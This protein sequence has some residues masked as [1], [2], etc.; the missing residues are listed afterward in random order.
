VFE[1]RRLILAICLGVLGFTIGCGSGGPQV[2]PV[3]GTVSFD[4]QPVPE[5]EIIFFPA[6]MSTPYVGKITNGAFECRLPAGEN[7]VEI[8]ATR[9][10]PTPAPDGLPNYESYIPSAYN[11]Q[12]TLTAS[13][14]PEGDNAF[15][16]EL[17]AQ[18]PRG[19]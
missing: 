16:F 15:T 2:Y 9:E 1:R 6:D 8:T 17:Q 13:V 18:S 14:T 19:R 7:R 4:G 10:S 3:K 12:S 11:T 5:G